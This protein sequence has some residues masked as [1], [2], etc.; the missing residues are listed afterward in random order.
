MGAAYR[1]FLKTRTL[2]PEEMTR[3]IEDLLALHWSG[4][5]S[6]LALTHAPA[7]FPPYPGG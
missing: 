1:G 3:R 4:G 7:M 5:F 2:S 6:P